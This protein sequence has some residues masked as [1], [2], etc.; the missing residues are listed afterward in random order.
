MVGLHLSYPANKIEN[1][2]T[3][4]IGES[5]ASFC[6]ASEQWIQQH[7]GQRKDDGQ[8]VCVIIQLNTGSI[9][10]TLA[11]S[12]CGKSGGGG[13]RPNEKEAQIF[14]LWNQLH[15]TDAHWTAGNLTA[16]VKQARRLV[17]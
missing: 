16:F 1:M 13:R 14:A 4:K 2:S 7:V 11:T 3:I 6:D 8:N 10:M 5:E 17:C 9:N 15:L 12:G